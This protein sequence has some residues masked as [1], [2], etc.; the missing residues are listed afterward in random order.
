VLKDLSIPDDCNDEDF[1]REVAKKLD[2]NNLDIINKVVT[3]IGRT[4][5]QNIYEKTQNVE[6][7]GGM[8]IMVRRSKF[9]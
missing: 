3:A 4:Q 9:Y 6:K 2:E 8:L 1:G 7:K 5:V